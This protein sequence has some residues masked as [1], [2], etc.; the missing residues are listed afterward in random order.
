MSTNVPQQLS[1]ESNADFR[2]Y[3]QRELMDR[4]KRNPKY[5]LRSFAKA[6]KLDHSTLSQL[7]R[8]SRSLTPKM[9]IRVG[10]TLGLGPQELAPFIGAIS[11]SNGLAQPEVNPLE[12]R[13]LSLDTFIAISDWY[14][15]AILEL[16]RFAHF[17]PSSKWIARTLGITISEVNVAVERL[18]RLELLSIRED[19]TWVDLSGNNNTVVANDFTSVALR[20]LQKQILELSISALEEVDKSRR[21]HS[22]MCMAI[23]GADIDETKRRIKAFRQ[24][25]C[26]Y[27]QREGSNPD[28]VY[29][30][31]VGFFPLTKTD[32]EK[33]EG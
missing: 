27:L 19:G 10:K 26:S 31:A 28:Q 8:G 1:D 24:E 3:L 30:L 25:L 9:I 13:T 23:N 7:L 33:E 17:E 22:S 21:E 18:V 6:L 11:P 15:D 29:Q 5:S 16:T 14:H 2:L 20:K 4:C 12:F 32:S